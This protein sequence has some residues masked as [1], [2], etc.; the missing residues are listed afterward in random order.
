MLAVVA[1]TGDRVHLVGHSSGAAYALL[2]AARSPSL[3]SLVLY[4]PPLR[5]DRLDPSIVDAL[6][7]AL[8]AGDPDSA[9]EVFFPAVGIVDHEVQ[10]L[11]SLESVWARARTGV[12]LVPREVR[13]A[14]DEGPAWLTA[15]DPPDV[16]TLYV[17]GA[18]TKASIFATLDEVAELLPKAKLQALP[19]QR[20]LAFAFD[21]SS[22]AQAILAFTAAQNE[23]RH[24]DRALRAT[25]DDRGRSHGSTGELK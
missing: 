17:H 6:Q 9:L 15:S 14:L 20:H 4:E 16:P 22:F 7:S 19:G 21:P 13:A 12:R 11:R 1:A 18:E 8:D 10:V 3:R 5:L 25:R 23:V 24:P 2:A